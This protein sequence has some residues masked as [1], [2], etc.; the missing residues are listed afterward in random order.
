MASCNQTHKDQFP[1]IVSNT[2]SKKEGVIKDFLIDL[3]A[4]SFRHVS[5]ASEG[6]EIISPS[7]ANYF[8][9]HFPATLFSYGSLKFLSIQK[10]SYNYYYSFQNGKIVGSDATYRSDSLKGRTVG[11]SIKILSFYGTKVDTVVAEQNGTISIKAF[12]K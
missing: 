11:G 6:V 3:P 4:S 1:E 10:E 12:I 8:A 2:L 7:D 9:S 5:Y